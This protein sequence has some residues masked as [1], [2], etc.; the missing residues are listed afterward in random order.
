MK[1]KATEREEMFEDALKIAEILIRK[2]KGAEILAYYMVEDWEK[3]T[4]NM[5]FDLERFKLISKQEK[6]EID[7]LHL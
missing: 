6:E 1:M 3:E 5:T 2:N 4:E 7:G